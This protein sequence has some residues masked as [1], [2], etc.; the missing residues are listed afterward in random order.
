MKKISKVTSFLNEA[1]GSTTLTYIQYIRA[2]TILILPQIVSFFV[3]GGG[4]GGGGPLSVTGLGVL[5]GHTV[6][7]Q[8]KIVL[9]FFK[10]SAFSHYIMH[11]MLPSSISILAT[12]KGE[13]K[14]KST[15]FSQFFLCPAGP[16]FLNDLYFSIFSIF[17]FSMFY[18]GY[19]LTLFQLLEVVPEYY[20]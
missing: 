8:S 1:T 19:L 2:K 14:C 6:H 7:S 17:L 16:N 10:F 12:Q 3:G 4:Q 11:K 20:K 5:S 9:F 18:T 15:P 13:R